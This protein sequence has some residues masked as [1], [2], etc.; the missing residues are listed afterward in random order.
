MIQYAFNSEGIFGL[1]ACKMGITILTESTRNYIRKGLVLRPLID[2]PVIVP[3][4]AA[5]KVA[6]ITPAMRNFIEFL[7]SYE[8][9]AEASEDQGDQS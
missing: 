2:S 4:Q 7:D 9:L 3:T 8:P 1:I 5:W 6:A